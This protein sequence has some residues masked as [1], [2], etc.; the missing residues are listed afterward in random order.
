MKTLLNNEFAPLTFSWGFLEAPL[1]SILPMFVDW[2]RS[3][4]RGVKVMEV[5]GSLTDAL[6]QL[7]PLLGPPTRELLFSTRSKWVAYFDNGASGGDPFPPIS[8]LSEHIECRGVTVTCIPNHTESNELRVFGAI[9]FSLFA[10]KPTQ[11]LNVVRSVGVANDGGRWRFVS[12]GDVQAFE[13][14]E[15]YLAK[16]VQDR[17]TSELLEE[18]CQAVGID[19]FKPDYYGPAGNVL[20]IAPPAETTSDKFFTLKEAQ[21]RLGL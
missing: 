10:P 13:R 21:Q 9:L 15:A 4:S 11:F 5:S 16:K 1:D 2:R 12:Q 19:P 8:Y 14:P 18:Y 6:C 7:Q 17:F 3:H 20:A